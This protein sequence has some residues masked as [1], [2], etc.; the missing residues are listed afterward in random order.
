MTWFGNV[1]VYYRGMSAT[2][3]TVRSRRRGAELERAIYDATLAEL[4]EVGYGRLTIE[5]VAARAR[6]GKAALYRRWSSRQA[7][8]L[9]ALRH[10]LPTL[11]DFDPRMPPRENLRAV[12]GAMSELLAGR[13][14]FPGMPVVAE[15][16]ADPVLR[17]AFA[18]AIVLPRLGVIESILEHA[19]RTGEIDPATLAP[20]AVRTGPALIIST[21]LIS[22]EP[23][24]PD[25][26]DWIVDT[27][28]PTR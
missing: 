26:L 10:A 6:T 18:A 12:L 19:Q 1:N 21:L 22:G 4:D 2:D 5:G 17:D 11:P 24:T 25:E 15:L 7:L 20:M 3:E 28:L 27:V 9:D 23:P 8:V 13:T 14:S 16:L